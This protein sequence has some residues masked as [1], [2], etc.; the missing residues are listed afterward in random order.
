LIDT[1]TFTSKYSKEF[2][3]GA[4][5]KAKD[6]IPLSLMAKYAARGGNLPIEYITKYYEDQFYRASTDF[7]SAA[8]K[9]KEQINKVDR[10]TTEHKMTLESFEKLTKN[11]KTLL[12]RNKT[13]EIKLKNSSTKVENAAV[14]LKY[15]ENSLAKATARLE[16]QKKLYKGR[17]EDISLI[18]SNQDNLLESVE[19]S[20]ASLKRAKNYKLINKAEIVLE[21]FNKKVKAA[22]IISRR[23]KK[24]TKVALDKV[25]VSK[26]LVE[27]QYREKVKKETEYKK[28]TD[29][30]KQLGRQY[31]K[32][33]VRIREKFDPILKKLEKQRD[34]LKDAEKRKT[35]Q[36]EAKKKELNNKKKTR[37]KKLFNKKFSNGALT[38]LDITSLVYNFKTIF[39]ANASSDQRIM[40][41]NGALS[42]F[43][44]MEE[45]LIKSLKRGS[46]LK[47]VVFK[48]GRKISVM[49]A[50][51]EAWSDVETITRVV[52]Q[53]VDEGKIT[54]DNVLHLIGSSFGL[55]MLF[56]RVGTMGTAYIYGGGLIKLSINVGE[57]FLKE[58]TTLTGSFGDPTSAKYKSLSDLSGNLQDYFERQKEYAERM[59]HIMDPKRDITCFWVNNAGNV[60]LDQSYGVGEICANLKNPDKF[61]ELKKKYENMLAAMAEKEKR[62]LIQK[63]MLDKR[64]NERALF[65]RMLHDVLKGN[66]SYK[67]FMDS[68]LHWAAYNL[69]DIKNYIFAD[70]LFKEYELSAVYDSTLMKDALNLFKGDNRETSASQKIKNLKKYANSHIQHNLKVYLFLA[71]K[72]K[73]LFDAVDRAGATDK[74]LSQITDAG[75]ELL[76]QVFRGEFK[77]EVDNAKK[78]FFQRIEKRLPF[79]SFEKSEISRVSDFSSKKLPVRKVIDEFEQVPGEQSPNNQVLDEDINPDLDSHSSI[80]QEHKN[81]LVTLKKEF[82]KVF[83]PQDNKLRT[84]FA[85]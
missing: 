81:K 40:A 18:S 28:A 6:K 13:V 70:H 45:R 39:N 63:E 42:D 48:M 26:E 33:K 43:F 52:A 79:S 32:V 62:M 37:T 51:W 75:R 54:G 49:N 84:D 4:V 38:V 30:K 64:L 69:V 24:K 83:I 16:Y 55:G 1:K 20:K 60:S 59:I 19:Q 25:V 35:E 57:F 10:L 47:K 68:P 3:Y 78:V 66:I 61:A 56:M 14:N 80:I 74:E 34:D 36:K 72:M 15:A 46:S 76:T 23:S 7:D 2:N 17:L 9:L 50:A 27:R 12:K 41:T 21:S 77:N 31:E 82:K 58:F 85:T 8:L 65:N 22:K 73:S 29:T 5:F 71:D 11:N 53:T 67:E 44:D